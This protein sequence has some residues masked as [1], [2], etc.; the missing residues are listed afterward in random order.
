MQLI[1]S[2]PPGPGVVLG[3]PGQPAPATEEK[4]PPETVR[5]TRVQKRSRIARP[6]G[7]FRLMVAVL[8]I[9]L[10]CLWLITWQSP[11]LLSLQLYGLFGIISVIAVVNWERSGTYHV[12]PSRPGWRRFVGLLADAVRLNDC[13]PDKSKAELEYDALAASFIHN[14]KGLKKQLVLV[15]VNQDG[16]TGKTFLSAHLATLAALL[17]REETI[18]IEARRD[19]TSAGLKAL[20]IAYE[21]TI[22][23]RNLFRFSAAMV[24]PRD[25]KRYACSSRDGVIAIAADRHIPNPDSFDQSAGR[26]VVDTCKRFASVITLDTGN[27]PSEPANLGMAGA[28]N[29]CVL[30]AKPADTSLEDAKATVETLRTYGLNDLLGRV[31]PVINN[32]RKPNSQQTWGYFDQLQSL[33]AVPSSSVGGFIVPFDPYAETDPVVDLSRLRYPTLLSLMRILEAAAELAPLPSQTT[34]WPPT[35]HQEASAPSFLP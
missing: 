12:V 7:P 31:L 30:V 3:A 27:G 11:E 29:V 2:K 15:I 35:A 18:F 26:R 25:L 28:G 33:V 9:S 17:L 32:S 20:G 8:V 14:I 4:D 23:V 6:N 1:R 13:V 22:T 24:M 34:D 16:G 5:T 21:V 19:S 10:L